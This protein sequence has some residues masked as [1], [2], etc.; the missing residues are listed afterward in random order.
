MITILAEADAAITLLQDPSRGACSESNPNLRMRRRTSRS[1]T[2]TS[3]STPR[4]SSASTVT[5][6][7]GV[8][9]EATAD[10]TMALILAVTRRIV[11]GDARSARRHACEW[12]PLK[13]LGASLQGEAPRHHRH[14]PHRHAR[15]PTARARS[16]W[17]SSACAAASLDESLATSDIVSIH[18]PLVARDAA[19]HRRRRR[20][21]D[22]ARRVPRQHRARRAG[23][24]E[25]ALRCARERPP[26][27]RGAR[28]LRVRARGESAAAAR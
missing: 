10:L 13:L 25:R 5:N 27:R 11:E 15:S 6:T 21:R 18:A 20:S 28:R 24:R 14:G 16:A 3:T 12:E 23:R 7:P 19:P 1:A 2:T 22:E 17:T 26:P 4:A 9:T 8:L